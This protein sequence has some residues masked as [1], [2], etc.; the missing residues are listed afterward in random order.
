[1]DVRYRLAIPPAGASH[2]VAPPNPGGA[3]ATVALLR[4]A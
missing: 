4:G 2:V 3:G 1:M